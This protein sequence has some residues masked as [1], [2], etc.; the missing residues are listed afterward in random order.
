MGSLGRLLSFGGHILLWSDCA[1][2]QYDLSVL[3]NCMP[4]SYSLTT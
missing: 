4:Y 1:D 2:A 3:L